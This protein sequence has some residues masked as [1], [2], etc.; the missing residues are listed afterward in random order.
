MWKGER[1]MAS[2]AKEGIRGKAS[3]TSALWE[4]DLMCS[5][6]DLR[7]RLPKFIMVI[8]GS[9]Y[10]Y[11]YIFDNFKQKIALSFKKYV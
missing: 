6:I 5:N 7:R 2:I 8:G 9:Y 10:C 4:K 11:N 3:I 1:G